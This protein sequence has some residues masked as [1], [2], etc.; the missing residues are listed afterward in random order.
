MD[1]LGYG[2]FSADLHHRQGGQR[3]PLQV[4]IEVTRRC[5]LECQH[6]YNNLPMG[7]QDARSREMTTEEHF[8]MLDELVE[9]GCFWLLYTGGE[10]FARR[11]FL[12]IYTYAKQKGFLDHAVHQW[13]AHQ[14]EDC[15]LPGGVAS[16]CD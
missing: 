7:D 5:P 1:Q 2:E 16:V 6:C 14:R 3:L 8:R 11:D 12:E 13:H 9:M 15:R 4:S 10:I